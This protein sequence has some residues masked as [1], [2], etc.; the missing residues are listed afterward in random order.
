MKRRRA[1]FVRIADCGQL[2]TTAALAG[3][4]V[5]DSALAA[6]PLATFSAKSPAE[7]I[8][9]VLGTSQTELDDAVHLT[10]PELVEVADY[11]PVSVD[12][13]LDNVKS[14]T[15]VSDQNPNPIIANFEL[16][17]RL[18]PYVSTRVRLAEAGALHALVK[19]GDSVHRATKNIAVT[20]GG[21]GDPEEGTESRP[22][23][24]IPS[25]N[26]LLRARRDDDGVVIRTLITHPMNPPLAN[27]PTG[28]N[29]DSGQ[30][31]QEVTAQ[32]NGKEVL[33]GDWSAGVS[34]N[35]YLSFKIQDV[36][37]GDVIRI[38]WVDNQG[39]SGTSDIEI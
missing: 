7:A 39:M 33:R 3:L 11:V 18:V 28:R 31:I 2:A 16:D 5:A 21:C 22:P 38:R 26:I 10:V 24:K 9:A 30:F 23:A 27:A 32:V 29:P 20:I 14:I 34:Q 17:S 37:T 15:I 6:L 1:G 4:L 35:P 25:D 36:R 12:T 8:N 19:A 13:T